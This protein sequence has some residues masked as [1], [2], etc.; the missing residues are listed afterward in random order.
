MTEMNQ[1][2][3]TGEGPTAS[4][5]Y[6]RLKKWVQSHI[7][8]KKVDSEAQGPFLHTLLDGEALVAVDELEFSSYAAKDGIDI[9]WRAL[10]SRFPQKAPIDSM[11]EALGEVFHLQASPGETMAA[12]TGRATQVFVTCRTK[13]RVEFPSEAQGWLLMH[14]CRLDDN[15][16]AVSRHRQRA[17]IEQKTWV[18]L[19][20][21]VFHRI[22]SE[23]NGNTSTLSTTR[24]IST[25][26]SP[27]SR[28][29]RT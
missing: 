26:Q 17:P 14:R 13:A 20:E 25:P 28:R 16:K 1:K 23:E 2:R 4:E 19:F 10:D 18:R 8:Y 27:P 7:F 29:S 15:Q 3:F 21:V 9:L 11:G 6:R 22:L 24:R 5:D 12:W